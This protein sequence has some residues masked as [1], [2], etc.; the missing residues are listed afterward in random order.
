ME[1]DKTQETPHKRTSRLRSAWLALRGEPVVPQAIRAEWVGWQIEF[2]NLLDKIS[3]AAARAY[4][5]DRVKLKAAEKTI[6][7]L[8]AGA[9]A[10][11][12]SEPTADGWGGGGTWHPQKRAMNRLVLQKRGIA[13]PESFTTNG[14]ANVPGT[15]GE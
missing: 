5:R 13:I 15:E 9:V 7:E 14:E 4:E 10:N 2:E 11:D 12:N 3:S 8:E 1:P 6:K